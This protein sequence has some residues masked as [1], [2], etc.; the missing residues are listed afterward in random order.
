M[1]AATCRYHLPTRPPARPPL[2]TCRLANGSTRIQARDSHCRRIR[3][4]DGRRCTP[5]APP[6]C[7]SRLHRRPQSLAPPLLPE[8][9]DGGSITTNAPH[10]RCR[11]RSHWRPPNH[12]CLSSVAVAGAE[13][14]AADPPHRCHRASLLPSP[15][16]PPPAQLPSTRRGRRARRRLPRETRGEEVRERGLGNWDGRGEVVGTERTKRRR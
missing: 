7:S 15:L 13:P 4:G 16:P 2:R 11:H 1:A 6:S 14:A 12:R 3:A 10:R 9:E 5:S 8:V